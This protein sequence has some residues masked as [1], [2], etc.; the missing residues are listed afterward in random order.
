MA[1]AAQG[2]LEVVLAV[3]LRQQSADFLFQRRR[4][5][6]LAQVTGQQPLPQPRIA[7][8]LGRHVVRARPHTGQVSQQAV[9][10][11]VAGFN[12]VLPVL[13]DQH[14]QF[15]RQGVILGFIHGRLLSYGEGKATSITPDA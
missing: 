7:L 6:R 1:Q 13:A 5:Q 14:R 11:T 3:A 4:R 8:K 15:I 2:P 9:G 12:K 10:D